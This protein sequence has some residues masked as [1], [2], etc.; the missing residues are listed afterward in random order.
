MRAKHYL[1][2]LVLILTAASFT[3]Y[4]QKKIYSFKV[5]GIEGG[6]IN[7]AKFKGKKILIVNTASECQYT[8]QYAEL[9][10]LYTTYQDKLVI[11]GFP[12]N[13]FGHQEMG[14]NDDINSFCKVRYGVSFP[15][16]SKVDVKGENAAPIYKWLC[17]KSENGVMDVTIK[18]NFNKFLID[19]KGRLLAHFP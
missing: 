7:F 11:V 3:I 10:S 14:S 12:C 18:W 8:Y 17:N 15:L 1:L 16:A 9:Q 2:L 4:K 19:E 5:D 6:K 13:Q